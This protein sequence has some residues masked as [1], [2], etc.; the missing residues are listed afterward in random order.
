MQQLLDLWSTYQTPV[1]EWASILGAMLSALAYFAARAAKEAAARAVKRSQTVDLVTELTRS[2]QIL[3]ELG[4]L[5]RD[6]NWLF[7]IERYKTLT[8]LLGSINIETKI[9]SEE[10]RDSIQELLGQLLVMNHK[11]E[12]ALEN[13]GQFNVGKS[14]TILLEAGSFLQRTLSRIQHKSAKEE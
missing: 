10:D 13:N 9:A 5:H 2:I 3:E 8:R 14:N 4:H 6:R 7:A 1:A 12:S 11:A